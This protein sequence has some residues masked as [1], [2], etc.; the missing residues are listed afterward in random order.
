MAEAS[1]P[2]LEKLTMEKAFA[3]YSNRMQ[4]QQR[5]MEIAANY[6][7]CGVCGAKPAV[8]KERYYHNVMSGGLLRLMC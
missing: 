5:L 1:E 8:M 2:D 6:D 3:Q 7:T 4:I